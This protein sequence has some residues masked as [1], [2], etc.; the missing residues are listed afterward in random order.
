MKL[1]IERLLQR[2]FTHVIGNFSQIRSSYFVSRAERP[3]DAWR[4]IYVF[5]HCSRAIQYIGNKWLSLA[6]RC[7]D[8]AE[9]RPRDAA[10]SLAACDTVAS[11]THHHLVYAISCLLLAS[12]KTS[13]RYDGI[14]VK[15]SACRRVTKFS[16]AKS[17]PNTAFKLH[18]SFA[19]V[20]ARSGNAS[21]FRT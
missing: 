1:K 19:A 13:L 3:D 15:D 14:V 5:V 8:F 6:G 16:S 17:S 10:N 18:R 11:S 4:G 9:A 7:R 2:V 21:E 20:A 12:S